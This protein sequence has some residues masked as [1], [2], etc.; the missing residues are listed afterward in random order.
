MNETKPEL[1]GGRYRL[2]R[3][4]AQFPFGTLHEADDIQGGR[5]LVLLAP[6]GVDDPAGKAAAAL[7]AAA[8]VDSPQLVRWS[9]GGA[10]EDGRL[11]LAA[12]LVGS[13]TFSEWVERT[14]GLEP[15]AA[16]PLV[17]Q[18]ARAL[19]KAEAV[20][21]HHHALSGEFVRLV[22]L[23]SGNYAVRVYGLG[24]DG[25]FAP[26]KA[27]KK[28]P[29]LGAPDYMSPEQGQGKTG[30]AGTDVYAVGI[31]LYEAVRGKPPFHAVGAAGNLSTTLKRQ[32]FEKPLALH[33]RHAGLDHIKPYE[34]IALRALAKASAQR[35][36]SLATL[37][38][39]LAKLITGVMAGEVVAEES[40]PG[41]A[42]SPT[43][44]ARTQI[45]TGFADQVRAVQDQ[46]D[47]EQ[48]V[49]DAR[50]RLA[51]A[52]G[53][54]AAA[55][56]TAPEVAAAAEEPA[57]AEAEAEAP[58]PA[59]EADATDSTE[60]LGH[61][62][63]LLT[64]GLTPEVIA[65][66]TGGAGQAASA[67][68]D[69]TQG[70]DDEEESDAGGSKQGRKKKRRKRKTSTHSAPAA[71]A[72]APPETKKPTQDDATLI[73]QKAIPA[74][75]RREKASDATVVEIPAV[76]GKRGSGS[77]HDEDSAW[78]VEKGTDLGPQEER[79]DYFAP[80]RKRNPM[81]L[82][83]G[84]LALV[85][86]LVLVWYFFGRADG[87]R[88]AGA[89]SAGNVTVSRNLSASETERIRRKRVRDEAAATDG[90][91][92]KLDSARRAREAL[93]Q[94]AL[95]GGLPDIA[96]GARAELAP[97]APGQVAD[98]TSV[99]AATD[100]E[101]AGALGAAQPAAAETASPP[102]PDAPGLN[103]PGAPEGTAE[104]DAAREREAAAAKAEADAT[105]AAAKMKAEADAAA[106]K[107]KAEADAKAKAEADAKAKAEAD[108]KAKAEADAKAKA[109]AEADAKAKAKAGTSSE[110]AKAKA[111]ADADAK[112][113][114]A[115]IERAAAE[116]RARA[117]AAAAAETKAAAGADA[118]AEAKAKA[119][120]AADAKAKAAA[121]AKAKAAA[122]ADA[123]AKAAADAKAKAAAEKAATKEKTT[124]PTPKET[125]SP[126]PKETADAK[127][128]GDSSASTD[129]AESKKS[130]T[131]GMAAFKAGNYSLAA[132]YF[133]KARKLDSSNHLAAK[134]LDMA[135][136]KMAE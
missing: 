23:G 30:L 81:V 56:P 132:A 26:Y 3:E 45:M 121:D 15:F 38:D 66:A 58:E 119:K 7:D 123:K 89:S 107:M 37:A 19:A 67:G 25:L 47:A 76:K 5:V 9:H 99:A 31:L 102:L 32:V 130:M 51:A 43:S 68:D 73:G 108:A 115:A 94:Q 52:T 101:E 111:R 74:N 136:A 40:E 44:A 16:A 100:G 36:D 13:L 29:F 27:L 103:G 41:A 90:E 20:G 97:P 82:I 125:T 59:D 124:S 60:A 24:L 1:L 133:A 75:E 105:V 117:K 84:I 72:A 96:G 18:V 35:Y 80:N 63:T 11:W 6:S 61:A 64:P 129:T 39:E 28:T 87:A 48:R 85:L 49:R 79:D 4:R 98:V 69:D 91:Q 135:R 42:K 33:M 10:T 46:L 113:T 95:G 70:G 128:E 2:D 83:A 109:K 34:E 127:P 21:V 92:R 122:A 126:T 106:A 112:A 86:V 71:S 118:S 93:A 110:A 88:D 62:D 54:D 57:Q 78:F 104:A 114:A 55:Q 131:L 120:A 17:H 14:D 8:R 77:E 134:Y 116:A 12:P 22:E 50:E 65:S 53:A